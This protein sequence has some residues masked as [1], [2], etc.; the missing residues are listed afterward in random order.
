MKNHQTI[1]LGIIG[2][3]FF[4]N[5]STAYAG[6]KDTTMIKKI[7]QFAVVKLTTDLSKLSSKE[8]EMIP[9][10]IEVANI[11]DE[12]FWMQTLGD[13]TLFL[14]GIKDKNVKKF[15]EINYGP[16]ERL[17]ENKSFVPEF[18]EKPLG[19]NYYPTDM[20]KAEF[21]KFSDKN[22]TSLY[23]LI[24]RN[25]DKSLKC[26]WFHEEYKEKVEKAALLLEKASLLAEDPG[27][28]SYLKLRAK[29]LLTDDYFESD[30]AW[31]DMKTNTLDFVVGPIETY[32]DALFG[33]KAAQ[34]AAILVKDKE[35]S[36]KLEKYTF[37]LPKLQNELPVDPKY[38]KEVPSHNSDMN[39]YDIIYYAGHA[40]SGGKTI[41]INLPNDEI[42]QAKKGS[43][44]LQLKNAMKAKFDKIL[45]PI[46]K[47]L[48]DAEQLI[49]VKFVAFFSNVMFHE[50]AH[51]LGIKNTVTGLGTIREALKDQYSAFEEAKA[52]ILGLFITTS[53]IEKGHIKDCTIEDAYVTYMAGLIRSVRFGATE[54]HGQANMM[55]LNYFEEKGAFK[56]NDKGTYTVVFDKM[57]E[58]VNSWAAIVVRF[59]G[60][61]D[62]KGAK[63]YNQENGII[64]PELQADLNRLKSLNIPVDVVFE[65]GLNT[66]GMKSNSKK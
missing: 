57:K 52:D 33:Y 59:E 11:M 51:G 23:T 37:F 18:K 14:N 66:L 62:Y 48:I 65:Q 41:A 54:A 29:A 53:L 25:N 19:A 6:T 45:I 3:I 1:L 22:K 24:R 34:E 58:A 60:E 42:V 28:N 13:K 38:K 16:W 35:W 40:N 32:E 21:D 47:Q 39:V 36:K 46:A 10:L 8:K 15:A 26:V 50:V 63:T 64:K 43:R 56:R 12:I 9:L 44:R 49:N 20:T 30:M 5:V 2:F 4:I 7:E 27:L 61:G 55:C 17:S 31:M